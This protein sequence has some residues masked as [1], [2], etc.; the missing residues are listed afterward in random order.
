MSTGKNA[1]EPPCFL[2]YYDYLL[3]VVDKNAKKRPDSMFNLDN[4]KFDS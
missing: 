2:N 4:A 1:S 3:P